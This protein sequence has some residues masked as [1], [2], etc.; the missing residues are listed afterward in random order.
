MIH[1][2][3]DTGQFLF[4]LNHPFLPFEI[5]AVLLWFE[6]YC[7]FLPN[8]IKVLSDF[9]FQSPGDTMTLHSFFPTKI[10]TLHTY[11]VVMLYEE[12]G[13]Y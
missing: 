7:G 8:H 13:N 1:T 11:F 3:L 10:P 4:L 12:N 2:G 5:T 6:L 9:V